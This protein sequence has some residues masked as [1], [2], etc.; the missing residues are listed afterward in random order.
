[1]KSI[2]YSIK[3]ICKI[4]SARLVGG[5]VRDKLLGKESNDIDL[6]TTLLP[7]EII[8][9]AK[10]YNLISIPTGIEHGTVTI[11]NGI[12][13]IEI[14]TL[15]ID[16][17]TDGRH[18]KVQFT[19][20]WYLDASRRDLTFNAMYLDENDKLYDYFN[21]RNDLVKGIV[22]FIGNSEKRIKEDALRILR[23]FRFYVYYGK[24][25]DIDGLKACYK[26]KS[27]LLNLSKERITQ[28]ILKI[29]QGDDLN[30]ISEILSNEVM[31]T[32]LSCEIKYINI[33]PNK[34]ELR[35]KLLNIQSKS[36]K[37]S[38]KFIKYQKL[39]E[40]FDK[41]DQALVK[42][43]YIDHGIDA[44]KDK[45]II[46]Q[47][48][49]NIYI[50]MPDNI[51]PFPLSGHDFIKA[52]LKGQNIQVAINDL[53]YWFYSHEDKNINDCYNK[54]NE[55]LNNHDTYSRPR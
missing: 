37:L 54:L 12:Q 43:F 34:L 5:I 32:I 42:I 3:E 52:G 10:K 26:Y 4:F 50:D 53:K 21:G 29:I 48:I 39:I 2:I 14:T 27:L 38:N 18:A 13:H 19:N 28:E 49:N 40:P 11:L 20:S 51:R 16:V 44:L 23:F 35:Y 41:N 31:Q 46:T 45:I 1:M 36:I 55:W 30:K 9:I 7:K 15:R 8:N 33:L 47:I 24:V 25:M 22:R 6:A 17:K